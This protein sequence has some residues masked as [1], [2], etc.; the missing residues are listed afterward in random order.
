MSIIPVNPGR[1]TVVLGVDEVTRAQAVD[2]GQL[3]LRMQKLYSLAIIDIQSPDQAVVTF[4]GLG[5]GPAG[6]ARNPNFAEFFFRVPPK[7]NDLSEPYATNIIATQNGGKFIESQGSIIKQVR[8]QGTTGLR[9][10]KKV[11]AGV[12][13]LLGP[14]AD[15]AGI[16]NTIGA[17]NDLANAV[18]T[19]PTARKTIPGTEA[20]GFDD[21]MFLR[22]L[23]RLYSDR[24]EQ[25][26]VAN[27]TVMVWRNAK[28]LD[29][30]I[31]EPL[32]FK[33]VQSSSSPMTYEYNIDLRTIA[34]YTGF[35]LQVGDD[36][37][38]D[39]LARRRFLSRIQG[40]SN[41]IQRITTSLA[42]NIT[43]LDGIGVAGVN[44]LLGPAIAL[45]NGVLAIRESVSKF[46]SRTMRQ[47]LTL[48]ENLIDA[49]AKIT[50]ATESTAEALE[51]VLT[52]S[53]SGTS[54][55][56][57]KL[58]DPLVRNL[59][60]L[61]V[62][63]ARV[64]T[65]KV[66]QDTVSSQSVA[67]RD[68]MM[69]PYQGPGDSRLGRV[70]PESGRSA[71]YIGNAPAPSMLIEVIVQRGE[72][73]RDI[74]QRCLND[75]V[76]WRELVLINGLRAPYI[77]ESGGPDI[78]RPGD[79]IMCP[80]DGTI[81]V[82]AS[83]VNIPNTSAKETQNHD[84]SRAGPVQSAFGR[85]LRLR[86]VTVSKDLDATD[87]TV[88]QDGDLSTIVGIP[89]VQQAI[90]LKFATER[91]ELSAHPYYG[92]KFP[93]GSKAGPAAFTTFQID[94]QSALL[95]D[96]RVE[97]IVDLDMTSL[98]DVMAVDTTVKLISTSE[99]LSTSFDLRS[100]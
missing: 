59:R 95:S 32:G 17:I 89:N 30:W 68:R 24:K 57:F 40:F 36:P 28:D 5:P 7:V 82:D 85:D 38:D 78:L 31:V 44:A 9:P 46:G 67:K 98:G 70:V 66:L 65:E 34:R 79:V 43:R 35:T 73:I 25:D 20:T 86:T 51:T 48:S 87:L 27:R 41:Q 4:E 15:F 74:A 93:L 84:E 21:I 33:L 81:G 49:L 92:S 29:Y 97:S 11:A 63:T 64:Q 50:S 77:S 6:P 100:R 19:D 69:Q 60:R 8:L 12:I 3:T 14:A 23:F 13:P 94:V 22:N 39:V 75:R 2:G 61:Q 10:N 37:L 55:N 52:G 80:A 26:T 42:N 71:A 47:A 76:R 56:R 54:S 58:Q 45:S 62:V 1:N 72:T 96:K 18:T 90:R 91:G 53:A 83:D 99:L 16:N 88:G